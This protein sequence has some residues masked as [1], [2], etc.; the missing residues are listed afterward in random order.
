MG[1]RLEE[2]GKGASHLEK[3]GD[4]GDVR[5]GHLVRVS[6]SSWRKK[7]PYEGW[8]LLAGKAP[9]TSSWVFLEG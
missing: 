4:W 8:E 1:G 6:S 2:G 3:E 9:L 5:L 7:S